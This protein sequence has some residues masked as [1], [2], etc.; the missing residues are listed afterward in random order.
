MA[1][2]I[3]VYEWTNI[4]GNGRRVAGDDATGNIPSNTQ[5]D[6]FVGDIGNTL[7]KQPEVL[8]HQFVVVENLACTPQETSVVQLIIDTTRFFQNPDMSGQAGIIG[9]ASPYPIGAPSGFGTVSPDI[10]ADDFTATY[11][12]FVFEPAAYVLP[13]QTWTVTYRPAET[14]VDTGTG[15][16]VFVKYTLY[17]GLDGLVANKLMEMS[18]SVTPDNVDWY[19]RTLMEQGNVLHYE[20]PNL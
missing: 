10:A 18:I 3:Q 5:V 11:P 4:G 7:A 19:K 15:V 14:D 1:M 20:D 8:P 17:D 2:R 9:L 13:G 6:I 12:S 16:A